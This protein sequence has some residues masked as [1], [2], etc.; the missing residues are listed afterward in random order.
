MFP[1]RPGAFALVLGTLMLVACSSQAVVP[2][3]QVPAVAADGTA[4][5][6]P[7]KTSAALGPEIVAA[8]GEAASIGFN[9]AAQVVTSDDGSQHFVYITE[10]ST[11][12]HYDPATGATPIS[13]SSGRKSLTAIAAADGVLVVAWTE[14]TGGTESIRVSESKDGGKTWTAPSV[15]ATGATGVSLAADGGTVVATWHRG[16]EQ[17]ADILFA[18]RDPKTGTWSEPI[19]VDTST[20]GPVWASVDISGNNVYVTWRDNRNGAYQ[21]YLRRSTDGGKTWLTEQV[22]GAANT[23][24][25]T[26]CTGDNGVVWLAHH[27]KGKITVLRSTDGGATWG[28]GQ[29]VGDGWF[30][31]MSCDAE[32]NMILGWEQAEGMS[33]RAA[34]TKAA[35]YITGTADGVLGKAQTL[36][37]ASGTTASVTIREDG[38]ADAVWIH[39]PEG[40]DEALTGQ[41]WRAVVEIS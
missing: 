20:A 18:R 15:L 21:V 37:E 9:N 2:Q 17:S 36:D 6:I 33:A 31:R 10:R 40:N 7:G 26:V 35:A 27:G 1:F 32:G 38:Y 14:G 3:S 16:S 29:T 12:W 41:L 34:T 4:E 30:P 11:V 28:A 13:S 8:A 25:P 39:H 19:Q 22:V 24:D 5:E 23:G